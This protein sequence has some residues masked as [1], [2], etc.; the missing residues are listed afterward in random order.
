MKIT[1]VRMVMMD[2]TYKI[3]NIDYLHVLIGTIA[4]LHASLACP[5][6]EIFEYR[7]GDVPWRN[8]VIKPQIEI[9][10][11]IMRIPDA[12]GLGIEFIEEEALRHPHIEVKPQL[13]RFH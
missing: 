11:G 1:D 4:T 5:N 8:T 10:N 9:Q 7:I 13:D 2:A 12:P 3:F 6:F